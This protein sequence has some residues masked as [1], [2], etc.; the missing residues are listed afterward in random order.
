MKN[1]KE[2][3]ALILSC[4]MLLTALCAVLMLPIS[5]NGQPFTGKTAEYCKE[6]QK[7]GFPEDYAIALTK[8]HLLHPTWEFAPLTVSKT[9]PKYTWDYVIGKETATESINLI[10]S[11]EAY[12]A[13]RHPTNTKLLEAGYYQPSTEAVEYFMDP[14][15]F[16]NEADIF[17]FYD[18]SSP[19]SCSEET[20]QAVLAGSFMA[21]GKLENGKTYARYLLEVGREVGIDPVF[22]ASKFL[23]EQGTAGTSP[24]ISGSCGD[25]LWKYY[26]EQIQTTDSGKPVSPPA[27]G[28]TEEALLALNGFYN[29]FNIGASGNGLFSIYKGAMQRAQ[30]GTDQKAADWGGSPAWDTMWKGIYGGALFIKEKYIDRCQATVYLQKFDVDGNSPSG[31]FSHQYMQNVAGSM[32]ESRKLYQFFA[33]NDALDDSCRFLIPVYSDMPSEPCPDPANGTCTSLAK[34]TDNYQITS[35]LTAPNSLQAENDALFGEIALSYDETLLVSGSFGHSYGTVRLQYSWDG[36]K[37]FTCSE[38]GILRLNFSGD[39]P[40]YGEH[41]L[42]VR[43]EAAYDASVS[44]KKQSRYFLCLALNVT[45]LPPPSV[46]VTL[47]SGDS[48]TTHLYYEGTEVLL[49]ECKESNFAGWVGSDGSFLPSGGLFTAAADIS[50][51]ALFL[52]LRPLEGAAI[53]LEGGDP[54]M[55][56]CAVM[57]TEEFDLLESLSATEVTYTAMLFCEGEATEPILCEL[58]L[59]PLRSAA[60][61][62]DWQRLAAITSPLEAS[63]YEHAYAAEFFVTVQY[64]GGGAKQIRASHRSDERSVAELAA[65]ALADKE[66]YSPT[67]LEYFR[68][69]LPPTTP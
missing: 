10:H 68:S 35:R 11:T 38:N 34:A 33:A 6:L 26:S 43:G 21:D 67:V 20:L 13:Y 3:L 52:H 44:T 51:T 36:E 16:L 22:L 32:S 59:P 41:I 23:Q 5:G 8:L 4:A 69:L 37:W 25:L 2:I 18:L 15:N 29:P 12:K 14:R 50:Y 45:V 1:K 63:E 55:R 61:N 27:S 30:R 28:E 54:T 31:N 17:Q 60:T 24:I 64:P 39:L 62:S 9:T 58:S 40:S 7:D 49:P 48:K 66:A 19:G 56:F 53:S 47:L 42:T 65:A 57:P 46:E